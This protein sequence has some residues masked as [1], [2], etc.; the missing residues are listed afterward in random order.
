MRN[1]ALRVCHLLLLLLHIG[2]LLLL[3]EHLQLL[4][5]R[6]LKLEL[7]LLLGTT[8][9]ICTSSLLWVMATDKGIVVARGASIVVQCVAEED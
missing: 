2:L 7:L 6:Y 1:A 4:L 3:L 9:V 5:N 8:C